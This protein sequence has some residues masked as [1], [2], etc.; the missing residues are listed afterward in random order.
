MPSIGPRDAQMLSNLKVT[1]ANAAKLRA[2]RD[3]ICGNP[4]AQVH[5]PEFMMFL[6]SVLDVSVPKLRKNPE[7]TRALLRALAMNISQAPKYKTLAAD[8]SYGDEQ[9]QPDEQTVKHYL[10]MLKDL[11]LLTDLEGWEPPM[12]AKSRVRTKPKRYFIDPSLPAAVL[13]ASPSALL[14]DTQTLGNLFETLCIRDLSV[15]LS[16]MPGAGNR[17]A[18]YRDDKGLEVDV[19][20]ELSD[21]R[22]GAIEIKLSDLKATDENAAK[23]KA[24]RH[25]ICGN[26]KGQ[27]R[28]P[29][30]MMFLTGRGGR[31][32]C[33]E[34]GILVVPIA[35]LG[36]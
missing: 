13:G 24:F 2:F 10:Q 16:A 4:R 17:I 15:Y 36:A 26:P 31:A 1:G 9:R 30:F 7:T 25:K 11:Y 8:M 23:L 27:V 22:W 34:D 14:R 3:K 6:A 32:Y 28:E 35:T 29:E 5:E 19:I 18:Y 20:V 21:G 33:R 12:R